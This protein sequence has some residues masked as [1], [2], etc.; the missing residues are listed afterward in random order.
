MLSM[1]NVCTGRSFSVLNCPCTIQRALH[2]SHLSDCFPF[3]I[4]WIQTLDGNVCEFSCNILLWSG[5]LTEVDF[6][7][8]PRLSRPSPSRR[9]QSAVNVVVIG[10]F[11][12]IMKRPSSLLLSRFLDSWITLSLSRMFDG[13]G[14]GLR[15]L[16]DGPVSWLVPSLFLLLRPH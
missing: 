12:C 7:H 15:P 1:N 8:S 13:L 14:G 2:R 3:V 10:P 9:N 6:I 11:W 4:L 16:V 5:D